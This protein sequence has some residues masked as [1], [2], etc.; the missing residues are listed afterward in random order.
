MVN[1]VCPMHWRKF[2]SS[3]IGGRHSGHNYISSGQWVME[4]NRFVGGKLTIEKKQS[5]KNPGNSEEQVKFRVELST[6]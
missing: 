5:G 3:Y 1:D 4:G 6:G 2:Q